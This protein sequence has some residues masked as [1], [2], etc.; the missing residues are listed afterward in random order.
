MQPAIKS[1]F[2]MDKRTPKPV[3]I[4]FSDPLYAIRVP[5]PDYLLGTPETSRRGLRTLKARSAFT[6]NPSISRVERTVLT[7]L[8]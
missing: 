4:L 3:I 1:P 8:K 5:S 7:T 2:K 6:L